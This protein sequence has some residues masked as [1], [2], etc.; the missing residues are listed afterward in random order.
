MTKEPT[1]PIL[2][3]EDPYDEANPPAA[4][5]PVADYLVCM[6][7]GAHVQHGMM[8]LHYKALRHQGSYRDD[9]D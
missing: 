8:K 9:A 7:C 4:K 6:M 2:R 1:W 5:P 3:G